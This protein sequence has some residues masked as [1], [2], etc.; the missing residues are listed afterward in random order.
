MAPYLEHVIPAVWGTLTTT[1]KKYVAEV[2]NQGVEEGDDADLVDS[3]G[4]VLGFENLVHAI[5]EIV[6]VLME[7]PRSAVHH[8]HDILR[9]VLYYYMED[10]WLIHSRFTGTVPRWERVCR[11]SC[12]TWC[13]TCKS[14]RNR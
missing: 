2:V 9:I 4:E 6:H 12:T 3:D 8:E 13:S 1:A 14:Q 5:F 7:T 10:M 11:T